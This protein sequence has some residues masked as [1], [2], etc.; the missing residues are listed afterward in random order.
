MVYLTLYAVFSSEYDKIIYTTNV[1]R[2]VQQQSGAL[3]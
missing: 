1:N 3:S 2:D